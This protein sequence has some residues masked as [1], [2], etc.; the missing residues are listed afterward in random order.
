MKMKRRALLT[1][2]TLIHFG[3]SKK[4]YELNDLKRDRKN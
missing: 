1:N 4:G 3:R 2:Q